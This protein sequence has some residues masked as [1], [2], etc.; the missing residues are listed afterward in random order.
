MQWKA[1]KSDTIAV[2]RAKTKFLMLVQPTQH[3]P[4]NREKWGEKSVFL[5]AYFWWHIKIRHRYTATHYRLISTT[6]QFVEKMYCVA[7]LYFSYNFP[8]VTYNGYYIRV[9]YIIMLCYVLLNIAWIGNVTYF[10]WIY[11]NY[12][13]EASGESTSDK[14]LALSVEILQFWCLFFVY[15]CVANILTNVVVFGSVQ[16][17]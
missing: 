15:A 17:M 14:V 12:C 4:Q 6:N 1:L 8:I 13:F 9:N 2:R 5:V 7:F 3:T 16:N 11:N 10:L